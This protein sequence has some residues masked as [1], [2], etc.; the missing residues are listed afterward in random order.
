MPEITHDNQPNPKENKMTNKQNAGIKAIYLLAILLG[1]TGIAL[2]SGD[3]VGGNA[4]NIEVNA[5]DIATLQSRTLNSKNA[6][7]TNTG[8]IA[9]NSGGITTNA[10]DVSG[11][12]SRVGSLQSTVGSNRNI[13]ADGIALSLAA[14]IPTLS[15]GQTKA[16][17][18][19]AG[20][21]DGGFAI[22]L[23]GVVGFQESRTQ[24]FAT[25]GTGIETGKVG[26]SIGAQWA[27]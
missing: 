10:G 15:A 7:E 8:S 27:W 21:Y 6:I 2:A 12:N 17:S 4:A 25:L 18:I 14:Q 19:G 5:D 11:I 16:L 20:Y 3:S 1:S 24:I 22:A 9:T 13:A 26:G 23:A